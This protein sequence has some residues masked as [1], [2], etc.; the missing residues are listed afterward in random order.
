MKRTL[1]LCF[2]CAGILQEGLAVQWPDWTMQ[3]L[4]GCLHPT[5]TAEHLCMKCIYDQHDTPHTTTDQ[6]Q[7]EWW[8]QQFKPLCSQTESPWRN[9]HQIPNMNLG[10]DFVK[11]PKKYYQSLKFSA[12]EVWNVVS[13]TNSFSNVMWKQE[14]FGVVTVEGQSI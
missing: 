13:T 6:R 2:M 4:A 14:M 10:P 9:R 8:V 1:T 3:G 7:G 5:G 12:E 11:V